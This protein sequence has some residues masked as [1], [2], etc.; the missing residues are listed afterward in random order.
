MHS[1]YSTCHVKIHRTT[2]RERVQASIFW[3]LVGYRGGLGLN[4]TW[5]ACTASSTCALSVRVLNPSRSLHTA[6]EMVTL[7][8]QLWLNIHNRGKMPKPNN[9]PRTTP[10]SPQIPAR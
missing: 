5:P 6:C 2:Q 3:L 10:L 8:R 7:G 1:S 4:M 9:F